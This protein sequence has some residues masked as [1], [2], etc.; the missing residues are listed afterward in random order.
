[1]NKTHDSFKKYTTKDGLPNNTIYGI[2]I[3]EENN[4]W[5]S[6]N[7]GISKLNIKTNSFENFNIIDGLQANEFNGAAYH[8]NSS[9][10]FIFGG[11]NGLNIFNPR[12]LT[13]NNYTPNVQFGSFEVNGKEYKSINNLKL[14]YDQ[15]FINIEVFLPDYKNI[16]GIQYIYK[17]EGASDEW[18]ILD[19][20]KINY[21]NLY[22]GKYKFKIKARN[23][24]GITSEEASVTFT[25]KPPF[26]AGKIA[27]G[28]YVLIIAS[29]GYYNINRVKMLDKMVKNR[30]EQ[31]SEEMEKNNKLL[32]KVIELERSKNNYFINLS[33]ELR[34]PLNVIYSIEQLITGL[35]KSNKV[36]EREKLNEY[37]DV[38]R[39]NTKRLLALINNLIDTSKMESSNYTLDIKPNDIVYI[40]EEATLSLKNY[41][42]SKGIKLVIDPE[43]EEKIINCDA[44]EIERCIVNIVGNA[45]KFTPSGGSIE[46]IIKENKDKVKIIIKDTGIGIDK[47]YHESIFDRF[48]QV[49]DFNE[50]KG[51]SGLGLTITKQIIDMHNGIIFVDS[52][53]NK[54]TIFT[55]ML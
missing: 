28:V 21:S 37:M 26:W 9:G 5:V 43:I 27:F 16:R 13:K 34:T 7:L 29:L 25:I 47:K 12:E 53:V 45:A 19:T 20:N 31:L 49:T 30:T 1:L 18:S 36:I 40:V 42:E 6:T 8:K 23:H 35:N 44:Y 48:N 38:V 33:H 17:L 4:P 52:E 22:P 2:L 54:G 15:N 55:I 41:I 10:E 11:I 39:R 14:R 51:G 46:V 50:N 24:N 32:N 3:D